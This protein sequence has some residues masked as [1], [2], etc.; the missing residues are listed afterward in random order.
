MLLVFLTVPINI[1]DFQGWSALPTAFKN[2]AFLAVG[3]LNT[4]E[5]WLFFRVHDGN[6]NH[7]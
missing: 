1:F 4:P 6:C 2:K 3:V 7:I 5:M